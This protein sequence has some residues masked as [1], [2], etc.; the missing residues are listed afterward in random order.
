MVKNEKSRKKSKISPA[1]G[2]H[3]YDATSS[4][5][6]SPASVA[7]VSPLLS[8]PPLLS[9]APLPLALLLL[10][11]LLQLPLLLLVKSLSLLLVLE[12]DDS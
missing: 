11:A 12:S 2:F 9:A 7:M 5:L 8:L 1:I 6:P 4:A 10:L 3:A